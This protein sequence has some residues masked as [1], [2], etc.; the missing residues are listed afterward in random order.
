M[1]DELAIV[2]SSNAFWQKLDSDFSR[3]SCGGHNHGKGE[4]HFHMAGNF[5]VAQDK[6]SEA[7][8]TVF[9]DGFDSANSDHRDHLFV[10]AAVQKAQ[11]QITGGKDFVS[12]RTKDFNNHFNISDDLLGKKIAGEIIAMPDAKKYL[13]KKFHL[14]NT[15]A[16][17]NVIRASREAA[18]TK[19]GKLVDLGFKGMVNPLVEI[20]Q[21]T[22]RAAPS[23]AVAGLA[24]GTAQMILRSAGDQES[25]NKLRDNIGASTEAAAFFVLVNGVLE[26]LSHSFILA[27]PA[28]ATVAAYDAAHPSFKRIYDYFRGPVVEEVAQSGTGYVDVNLNLEDIYPEDGA[29]KENQEINLLQPNPVVENSVNVNLEIGLNGVNNLNLNLA[30]LANLDLGDIY[31]KDEVSKKNQEINLSQLNVE[32]VAQSDTGYVDLELGRSK[33]NPEILGSF[34]HSSNKAINLLQRAK[35]FIYE[36]GMWLGLR[37]HQLAYKDNGLE[38]ELKTKI[39]ELITAVI[40]NPLQLNKLFQQDFNQTLCDSFVMLQAYLEVYRKNNPASGVDK[41]VEEFCDYFSRDA[42]LLSEPSENAKRAAFYCKSHAGLVSFEERIKESLPHMPTG[43]Q[44]LLIASVIGALY[45]ASAIY[46][47]ATGQEEA[48][49][50]YVT[51]FPDHLFKWLQLDQMYQNMGGG[52]EATEAFKDFFAGFNLAENSTHLGIAVAPFAAY[53]QMGSKM[54]EG[55]THKPINYLAYAADMAN[56]Y[57]TAIGDW[58]R[59]PAALAPAPEAPKNYEEIN[60]SVDVST[61]TEAAKVAPAPEYKENY[62]EINASVDVSTQNE[63]ANKKIDLKEMTYCGQT[64]ITKAQVKPKAKISKPKAN[65]FSSHLCNDP[66][67]NFKS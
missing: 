7:I 25:A 33:K 35:S 45:S 46:K 60:A 65:N 2:N 48:Y 44:V 53:S 63:A 47:A 19:A 43:Q 9:G 8:S 6:I 30:D 52:A 59:S 32:E 41:F 55:I 39:Q 51:N 58:F 3:A 54:F 13:V 36:D 20:A 49:S 61:Q 57:A 18:L 67:C 28:F 37:K 50:D 12:Q 34:S 29:S 1:Q 14:D 5:L 42:V 22:Y 4:Q 66:G 17:A 15:W 21:S 10:L 23:L 11:D 27:A 56:S 62:E 38:V 31:L 16:K 26:N 64:K 40:T 24:L